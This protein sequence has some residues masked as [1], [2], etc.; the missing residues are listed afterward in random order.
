MRKLFFGMFALLLSAGMV[1]CNQKQEAQPADAAADST[2]QVTEAPAADAPNLA[3]VVAKMKA[4]GANWNADQWKEAIS[5]ALLATKPILTKMGEI[6]K[7]MESG[8]TNA[9][10]EL[11]AFTKSPE[12]KDFEAL[13]DECNKVVEANPEAKKIFDDEAWVKEFKEANGIPEM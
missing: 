11:E 6:L 3:D 7:K 4:E 8:D 2:A 5:Q 9:A 10:A 13:M 1:S 12:A